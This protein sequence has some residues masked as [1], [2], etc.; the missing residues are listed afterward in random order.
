MLSS[1]RG[2]SININFQPFEEEKKN[3]LHDKCSFHASRSAFAFFYVST[4]EQEKLTAQMW[5]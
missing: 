3:L 1:S 4:R 5:F 2:K